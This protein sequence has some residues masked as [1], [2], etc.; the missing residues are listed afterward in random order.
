M[1]QG[2]SDDSMSGEGYKTL[3]LAGC[4]QKY[5]VW[6]DFSFAW[7]AALAAEPSIKYFKM[8][9]ARALI[10][11]FAGWTAQQRNDKITL[12][13]KVLAQY[14]P[15]V[16]YAWISRVE[17][18]EIVEPIIPYMLRHPYI[19]LFYPLIIKQAEWQHVEG[20]KVPTDFVFDEQGSVGVEAV[21]WYCHFRSLQRP[22]ISA[23]MGSTPIFRD[24][25]L[26]LP[27][28]A[29][30]LAAWHKRRCIENPG[31]LNSHS[32]TAVLEDLNYAE[33][34]LDR[35]FLTVI[36]TTR[37]NGRGSDETMR[38]VPMWSCA[39]T[40]GMGAGR[41]WGRGRKML[42]CRPGFT[43]AIHKIGNITVI[44]TI[45]S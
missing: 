14:K 6:A 1:N 10:K 40:R 15:S 29:A 35:Q 36:A 2:F 8:R 42:R 23:L 28:Q 9:E 45:S 3:L 27:L 24:D 30:D 17:F 32:P 5:S 12:L 22:H 34:H 33:V 25:K 44:G 39:W 16:T 18:D 13:A 4:V 31:E 11:E 43:N 19:L 7:E 20:E 41:V 37:K 26:V 21:V 38:R